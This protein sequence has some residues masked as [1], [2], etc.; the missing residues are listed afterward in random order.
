MYNR[1]LKK[2]CVFIIAFLFFNTNA[3][4]WVSPF[5]HPVSLRDAIYVLKALS[6]G[7][8][9][10]YLMDPPEI[11]TPG[12]VVNPN[13]P[14][15]FRIVPFGAGNISDSINPASNENPIDNYPQ[16]VGNIAQK[17][18]PTHKWW[19]SIPFHGEM[20]IDEHTDL[21]YITPDPLYARISNKGVRLL[22]IPC[23][24]K[25]DTGDLSKVLY[26]IHG[27]MNEVYDGIAVANSEYDDLQAYLKDYSDG[28]VT[29]QW[30]DGNKMVMEATFVHGS[31]YAFFR[32]YRGELVIKTL[33]MNGAEKGVFYNKEDHLGV[34]TDVAGIRSNF[35][36]SG[37]G[38]TA[39]E[40][41]DSNQITIKNASNEITI[42]LL[43]NNKKD[44]PDNDTCDFFVKL[45]RNTV[46]K[47]NIDY[48][49]NRTNNEVTVTHT[50]LDQSGNPIETL[51]GL[52]PL[53]W[54]NS[55][56]SLT[57]YKVRSARGMIK[58]CKT[59]QFSYDL[60]FVGVLPYL[61]TNTENFDLAYLQNLV[62][63]YAKKNPNE[64]NQ[65]TDTYWS[66]KAYGKMAEIIAI[67]R[68]LGMETEAIQFTNW[69]KQ[70]LSDWFTANTNGS[71]DTE[72][73]FVYDSNW[74]T[75][76]GVKESFYTHQQ[77]N[78]H[79]F[80]YGYFVRAAAEICRTDP[81]WCSPEQYGPMIEL[82]I[83]DY[84]GGKNDDMFPYLRHF[85]PANGFSWASGSCKFLGGNNNESTSE[86]ANAYGAIILYGLITGNNELVDR[87]IY[88]HASTSQTYWEYWNNIDRFRNSSDNYSDRGTDYDNFPSDYPKITTSIIWGNGS[89]FATWFSA[90][91]AHIL[92]I[93]GLP[94]NPL[95]FHVGQH[96]DYVKQYVSLGLSRSSNQKPSGLAEGQWRDI[97]WELWAM[98]D[99]DAAISDYETM[100]GNYNPENGETK[101][102]TYH[103]L[104]TWKALGHLQTGTG[105]ITADY[106]AAVMFKNGSK[107]S[108]VVYNFDSSEKEVNFSD[109][110]KVMASPSGF[111]VRTVESK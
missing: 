14:E 48:Q 25:V 57:S 64:W 107:K 62:R 102:H 24:L 101:A 46:R 87:G 38:D 111:T 76:L 1:A 54:K 22:G 5:D 53:H 42:T 105:E 109:G 21:A 93:Q 17:P 75:L 20:T 23:G 78:D 66:G 97:W 10:Q 43:P 94:M 60:P 50:Y 49:V 91:Y 61:P 37:E 88:L 16:V 13:D 95:I 89:A 44:V 7:T 33:T 106:P 39:F 90:E 35:I 74:N 30:Q 12:P 6:E 99:A 3:Y 36:I 4:A 67:A 47:V 55:T 100:A 65:S 68:S 84:A 86:A 31:P 73:Y 52:H 83:R 108:Y 70:E 82:L 58:Y 96:E 27:H 2:S 71:L 59:S 11:P 98:T 32:V 69:L 41:I 103:W 56:I 18:T 9:M 77:L 29:I 72:K 45:A 80:H 79:H 34:W 19:G 92:G 40:N 15:T 63:D 104:H 85:D 81:S 51:T 110:Q 26:E 28:S 8:D